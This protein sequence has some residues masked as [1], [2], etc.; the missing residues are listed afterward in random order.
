MSLYTA[1]KL[2]DIAISQ[3]GYKEKASNNQLDS[4]SANAGKNNY[5]KYARDLH[6]AGYYNGDKNGYSWCDV[7]VDWCFFKL[8]GSK[9][10]AEAMECQTGVYG[11]GC[12]YSMRYYQAAKRFGTTPKFGA[13]IFF[14][15]TGK[16]IDHTGIVVKVEKDKIYTVEGNSGN[17]VSKCVYPRNDE[18]I[19][20][21]GYPKYDEEKKEKRTYNSVNMMTLKYGDECPEVLTMQ[22]MLKAYGYAKWTP[23]GKFGNMTL[24]A[25][26]DFQDANLGGHDGVCGKLTW[27]KLLLGK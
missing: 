12:G 10:K 5:T 14:S 20:G 16:D 18:S 13:Q 6:N 9:E 3:I 25:L 23:D 27:P 1:Q 21:Y 2:V 22:S 26:N 17:E 7:F 8:T 19:C 4:F 11:A 24:K 15:Y